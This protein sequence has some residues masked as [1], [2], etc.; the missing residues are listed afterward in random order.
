MIPKRLKSSITNT[1]QLDF[2]FASSEF[3]EILSVGTKPPNGVPL[4]VVNN[5]REEDDI[6]CLKVGLKCGG[7]DGLSGTRT[8]LL[9]TA[10][11]LVFKRGY[12]ACFVAG[13]R[14]FIDGLSVA[15][16]IVL[17]IVYRNEINGS[18]EIAIFKTGVTL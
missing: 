6:S 17:E 5:K 12:T 18:K 4:P 7:S 9:R 13:G 10:E 11:R 2:L 14:V 3:V 8:R 15:S 1:R 16:E